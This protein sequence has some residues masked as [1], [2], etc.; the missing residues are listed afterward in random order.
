MR[1]NFHL[2]NGACAKSERKK[3]KYFS[4][5]LDDYFPFGGVKI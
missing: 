2:A 3:W 5:T 4:G 1:Y